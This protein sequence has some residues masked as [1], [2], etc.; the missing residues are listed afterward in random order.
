MGRV[1]AVPARVHANPNARECASTIRR[2]R[3]A[4][5]LSAEEACMSGCVRAAARAASDLDFSRICHRRDVCTWAW[6]R[7]ARKVLL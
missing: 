1:N 5:A 2:G 3:G 7:R 6:V 4:Y